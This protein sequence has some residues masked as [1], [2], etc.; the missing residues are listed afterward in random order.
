MCRFAAGSG[1]QVKGETDLVRKK[2]FFD[3]RTDVH[4]TGLLHV[5]AT[6]MEKR[7]T[8]E[9]RATVKISP[10]SAPRHLLRIHVPRRLLERVDA[11]ADRRRC[12]ESRKELGGMASQPT[13]HPVHESSRQ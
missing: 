3:Y 4:G 12:G 9:G 7:I 8:R 2:E 11:Y 5:I 13:G 6:G 1:A 10:G